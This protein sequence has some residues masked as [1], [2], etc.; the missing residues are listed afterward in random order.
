M[1]IPPVEIPL[2]ATHVNATMVSLVMECADINECDDNP[3]D[4]SATCINTDGL[5][6]HV[7]SVTE[8]ESMT[9]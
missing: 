6:T 2:V 5:Y 1:T 3:C 8:A 9:V 7:I 4:G